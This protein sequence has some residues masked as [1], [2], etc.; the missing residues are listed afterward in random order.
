[1]NRSRAATGK[2]TSDVGEEINHRWRRKRCK[3]TETQVETVRPSREVKLL[4]HAHFDTR[5]QSP[6]NRSEPW[7]SD[8][9]D[10]WETRA[11]K[12]LRRS[13]QVKVETQTGECMYT[14]HFLGKYNSVNSIII[15]TLLMFVR[16]VNILR[17]VLA[18]FILTINDYCCVQ[19]DPQCHDDST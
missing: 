3:H 6:R 2:L 1:M 18:Y 14:Q 10:L 15:S 4:K 7:R 12:L 9:I 17:C 16:Y 19:C 13:V 8:V 5:A 11:A